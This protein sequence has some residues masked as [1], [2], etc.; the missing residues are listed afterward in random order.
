MYSLEYRT[1]KMK[2]V[3]QNFTVKFVPKVDKNAPKVQGNLC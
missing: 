1:G 3:W 2:I